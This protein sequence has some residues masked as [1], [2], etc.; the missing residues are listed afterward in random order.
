MCPRDMCNILECLQQNDPEI[1]NS[2]FGHDTKQRTNIRKK[3]INKK[4][5]FE[6]I[7]MFIET[8]NEV[9]GTTVVH[10]SRRGVNV[11]GDDIDDIVFILFKS[12][13]EFRRWLA[14]ALLYELLSIYA[15]RVSRIYI[16][17]DAFN[18]LIKIIRCIRCR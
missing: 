6:Y 16:V 10:Y 13:M 17:R 14:A 8:I 7:S 9:D 5:R 4:N 11:D 3:N 2:I 18:I 12:Y 1:I 15:Y